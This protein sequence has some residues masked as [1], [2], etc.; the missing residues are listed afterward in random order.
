MGIP[1]LILGESGS[2]KTTSLRNFE[3]GAVGVISVINK[4]LPFKS[5]LKTY[6]LNK[7]AK[8]KNTSRYTL[9]RTILKAAKT[10]TM[11][12]D[13]S[14]YLICYDSFDRAKIKGYDKR[15]VIEIAFAGGYPE[16]LALQSIRHRKSWFN[17]Y[18][19]TLISKLAR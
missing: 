3:P 7:N 13:D 1:I 17:D 11:V 8:L 18:V 6:P 4:P 19:D 5:S 10:K 15:K 16:P 2:G 12:I 9:L 14:Q